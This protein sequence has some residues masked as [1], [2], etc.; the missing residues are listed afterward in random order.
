MTPA[1][2]DLI[3][4]AQIAQDA[5][6]IPQAI[7]ILTQALQQEPANV[8]VLVALIPVTSNELQ[9]RFYVK[10]LQSISPNHAVLATVF[11]PSPPAPAPAPPLASPPRQARV[12]VTRQ[13]WEYLVAEFEY[14]EFWRLVR[15]DDVG[16]P[17][18]LVGATI[19]GSCRAFGREGW[20][21]VQFMDMPIMKGKNRVSISDIVG[22]TTEY[23]AV[24]M[25]LVFKRPMQGDGD[26]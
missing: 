21:A 3:R 5:G 17:H 22:G 2:N 12:P 4:Q 23:A 19:S 9:R 14:Q 10:Q 8:E 20:E 26:G 1:V 7:T 15:V 24:R 6:D 16:P 11:P 18:K 13:G 25:V